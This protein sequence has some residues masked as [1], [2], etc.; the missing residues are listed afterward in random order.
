MPFIAVSF[1]LAGFAALGLP[2]MAGFAAELNIFMGAFSASPLA[3]IGAGLAVLSIIFTA[4]YVLRGVNAVLHGPAMEGSEKLSDA[5]FV[6]KVPLVMLLACILVL[7]MYPGPISN[8]LDHAL[9]PILNN[10][11]R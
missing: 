9:Q 1:V 11:N 7:G 10:L 8:L 5:A 3:K 6:D 2:G 4:V